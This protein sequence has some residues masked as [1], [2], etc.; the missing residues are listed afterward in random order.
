MRKFRKSWIGLIL[1]FLFTIS[2]FFWRS[3]SR[4]SKIFDSD[5]VLATV[6]NTPISTTKFNRTL[7]MNIQ[8]FNQ[9]LGK[10]L[11]SDDIKSFQIHQLALG[12]I[13]K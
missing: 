12:A 7:Q 1:V 5:N 13:D 8:Q 2:L 9:I 4:L 6:G 3:G 10:E 11:T